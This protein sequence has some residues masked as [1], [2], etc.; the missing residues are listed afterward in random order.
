MKCATLLLLAF[1]CGAQALGF[2]SPNVFSETTLA[3]DSI[4]S[5]FMQ[6][7]VTS[8]IFPATLIPT[9]WPLRNRVM[10]EILQATDSSPYNAGFNNGLNT[11]FS[12][13][14]VN[15]VVV[16]WGPTIELKGFI[17][18]GSQVLFDPAGCQMVAVNGITSYRMCTDASIRAV[19]DEVVW[20]D[21][22][23][24]AQLST[25]FDLNARQLNIDINP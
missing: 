15:G 13:G 19:V 3:R 18:E 1:V 16:A 24:G 7:Y 23:F 8:R 25:G 2:V 12:T 9:I 6:D 21:G 11:V 20:N 5:R 14:L 17:H 4:T 10:I 22:R